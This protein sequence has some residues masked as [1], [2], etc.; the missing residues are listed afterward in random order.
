MHI[1]SEVT[2]EGVEVLFQIHIKKGQSPPLVVQ[3][4]AYP[5]WV[6]CNPQ[7]W[8]QAVVQKLIFMPEGKEGQLYDCVKSSPKHSAV[9]FA[10]CDAQLS[11]FT[12]IKQLP[13]QQL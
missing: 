13:Q 3:C 1:I 9:R 5:H 12:P 6:H 2:L 4:H 10:K 7:V 11:C 8:T